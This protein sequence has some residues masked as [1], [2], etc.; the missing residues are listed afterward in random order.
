[1]TQMKKAI[2]IAGVMTG[3]SCDGLDVACVEFSGHPDRPEWRPI[4]SACRG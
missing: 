2:R 1:M 3:T 4:C